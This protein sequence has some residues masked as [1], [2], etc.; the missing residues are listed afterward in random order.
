MIHWADSAFRFYR[1][2]ILSLAIKGK[3]G[4]LVSLLGERIQSEGMVYNEWTYLFF[5]RV[6]IEISPVFVEAIR[7][8]FPHVVTIFDFGCGT[9]VYVHEFRN[10]GLISTGFEYS[11]KARKI[12]SKYLKTELEPFNLE[13]F[14]EFGSRSDLCISL[15]VA[16]HLSPDL[17]QRLVDICCLH[18]P[19][20]VFSAAPPGQSG[21]GHVNLQPKSYWIQSFEDRNYQLRV[22]RTKEFANYLRENLR[23][24]HWIADNCGVYEKVQA[25]S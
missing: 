3:I 7:K 14:T 4:E 9:G 1:M 15:E 25:D 19:I 17:G 23:I 13:E 12:A 22:S 24:G 11:A 21:Q 6:A 18:S 20:V 2:S 5:H 10:Q 8:H 16:E